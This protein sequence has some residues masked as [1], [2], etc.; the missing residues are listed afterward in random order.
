MKAYILRDTKGPESLKLENVEIGTVHSNEVVIKLKAASLNRRDFFITHGMYPGMKL[1]GIL[2]SDGA[3][4]I[5]AIGDEVTGF[6]VGDEVIMN[7]SLNWGDRDDINSDEFTVLGMPSNGTFAEFI[8]L[9]VE[10]VYKKPEYLSWEE[11]A[12]IPLAALTAYRSLITRGQLQ[13]ND[14]VLIPGIGSG[15]ALY[16]LQIAEAFGSKVL[17]TSSSNEK[18][19]KAIEIGATAGF[20]YRENDWY[21][22]LRKEYGF[23]NLTIDG[24]GGESFNRL[25]DLTAQGG[26]I[27]SFGATNGPVPQTVLPKVFFKNM[28]IRGTTMGSP[29]EFEQMLAFFEEHK[30]KPIIDESFEFTDVLSALQRM[31]EGNNFGKITIK[32]G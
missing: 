29:R 3:G 14:T 11:A 9:P 19:E 21:K 15:V 22:K 18:I 32:I 4:V 28:D 1:D 30:I 8:K 20:N 6:T 24:V 27:V 2:G 12:A 16:A 5:E 31:G 13:K 23:V 7:P 25:I 17:V 10:N 26:R